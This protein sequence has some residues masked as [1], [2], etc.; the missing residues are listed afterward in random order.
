MKLRFLVF[1]FAILAATSAVAQKDYDPGKPAT[2]KPAGDSDKAF[3]L[4][5]NPFMSRISL[6]TADSGPFA[7]LGTGNTSRIFG[8]IDF[9]AYY[10]FLH[11]GKAM[12]GVDMRDVVEHGNS[13]SSLNS[14]MVG[15]RISYKSSPSSRWRPYIMPQIGSG[16]SR[17]ALS[18]IHKTN[19]EFG[20]SAGADYRLSKH[21]DFRAV[22]IGYGSVTAV[23]SSEFNQPTDIGSVSLFNVSTGFVFRFP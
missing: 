7:F 14:F 12:I 1:V 15:V 11:N 6:S 9:G 13:G 22:E 8:G 17:S 4:Y 19:V 2:A 5:L 3:G 18:P 23:N 21:V 16:R 10:D 20:L